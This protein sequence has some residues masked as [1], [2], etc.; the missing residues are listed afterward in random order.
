VDKRKWP[1]ATFPGNSYGFEQLTDLQVDSILSQ[2]VA[3]PPL[4][5][6]ALEELMEW[7]HERACR[8]KVGGSGRELLIWSRVNAILGLQSYRR[9]TL[10]SS[11]LA[12]LLDDP[13]VP[14]DPVAAK[15][16]DF[17][18]RYPATSGTWEERLSWHQR[19]REQGE[20]WTA[21]FRERGWPGLE[22]TETEQENRMHAISE[23]SQVAEEELWGGEG[24]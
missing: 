9:D 7:L 5:R 1:E 3:C 12:A 21:V 16:R 24:V 17:E 20:A 18:A 22:P 13:R 8:D 11:W 2:T 4:A 19:K 23:A 15:L 10:Q 14:A 6:D